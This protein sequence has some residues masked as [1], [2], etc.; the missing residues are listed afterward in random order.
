MNKTVKLM[1]AAASLAA[2]AAVAETE[3]PTAYVRELAGRTVTT[4]DGAVTL[5]TA[6]C[7][8]AWDGEKPAYENLVAYLT[9]KGD[10]ICLAYLGWV[11]DFVIS[12]D[13]PVSAGAVELYGQADALGEKWAKFPLPDF[14]A[15]DKVR[16]LN[17]RPR[18]Y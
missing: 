10:A 1:L 3:T 14:A 6:Y 16:L 17:M 13:K 4:D 12:F 8:N 2:G 11:A 7:F 15:N 18:S 5:G 9:E